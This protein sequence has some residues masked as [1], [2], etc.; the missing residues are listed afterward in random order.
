[1]LETYT[2]GADLSGQVGG[3]AGG[4]GG[5]L[6]STQAGGAA[7]YHVD[8][9]GNIVQVSNSNQTQLAKYTYSPFG[10]VLLKEGEFDSR[11]QF[12]TKEYDACTGLNYYGYRHYNPE[13]GRWFNRDPLSDESLL[14]GREN[15]TLLSVLHA[16]VT[17][18][19]SRAE[20]VMWAYLFVQNN[21]IISYDIL[22]LEKYCCGGKAGACQKGQTT[23]ET[24][25]CCV[26]AQCKTPT[27]DPCTS[28]KEEDFNGNIAEI[29][30][31]YVCKRRW[32]SNSWEWS[33]TQGDRISGPV[34]GACT[35]K[36][37]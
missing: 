26:K 20:I 11:Y 23:S 30:C 14:V 5:I 34:A 29:S 27:S 36:V 8:F 7:Y 17:E 12:S 2:H 1:M 9:N 10:E 31:K 19:I 24:K 21:P 4:I 28:Q 35:C 13:M 18:V 32:G 16:P 3:G 22:G 15:T 6:A 37:P 33:L 25:Y